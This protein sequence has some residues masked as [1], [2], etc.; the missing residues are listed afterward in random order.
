M[1]AK[2]IFLGLQEGKITAEQAT[3][4]LL[5]LKNQLGK[6]N[7]IINNEIPINETENY[8]ISNRRSK[9]L[10]TINYETIR[11]KES[12]TEA[13]VN[14][15]EIES[16]IV[17]VEMKDLKSKNTFSKELI[18]E[19]MQAFDAINKNETYKAVILTGYNNYF[20][21]GGSKDGLLSIYTGEV[22]MTDFSIYELPLNCRIPVIAAMKGHAIGGGWCLGMFCDFIVMSEESSYMCNH[23][24]YGFTP[25][26]G[27]TLIFPEKLGVCLAQE[28]L[29]FGKTFKGLELKERGVS[30]SIVEKSHVLEHAISL[31]RELAIMPVKSLVLLK[32]HM[33]EGIKG[34]L[35]SVTDKEWSMQKQTLVNNNKVLEN[36][37]AAFDGTSVKSK[38]L[39]ELKHLNNIFQGRPVIWI[40]SEDGGIDGYQFMAKKSKRPFYAIETK[41]YSEN[42][43]RYQSI[44]HLAAYYI[45]I[46][47]KIQQA[48]PYDLGGY[49]FGGLLAYEIVRQLQ[50]SGDK[51]DTLIMVDSLDQERTLMNRLTNH[52]LLL[53]GVNRTLISRNKSK[54][55]IRFEYLIKPEEVNSE[56]GEEEFLKQLI[57]IGK[58][59]GL[60]KKIGDRELF[61]MFWKIYKQQLLLQSV[62]IEVLPLNHP[63]DVICYYCKNKNETYYGQLHPYFIHEVTGHEIDV[64]DCSKTW[65]KLLPNWNLIDI[66]ACN[67]LTLLYEPAAKS[68]ITELCQNIYKTDNTGT[69]GRG[70]KE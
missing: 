7:T 52:T 30:F 29:F 10:E 20:A 53:Q 22:K 43:E 36:I 27:A 26:D 48:G 25:G 38:Q 65:N 59:R 42:D 15:T 50:E 49:S 31:A 56:V 16:G 35:K 69:I 70:N 19:L 18:T 6:S 14:V 17:Q 24:K 11:N 62:E 60:S 8:E 33:N 47:K 39:S 9:N 51:V 66:E 54:N 41:M 5:A 55:N 21:C 58:Q 64:K 12:M 34:R 45:T 46:I 2:E 67:H 13:V 3:E 57:I 61:D 32:S 44:R 1:N 37:L 63:E 40:H 68:V 4:D 28:V 23:M